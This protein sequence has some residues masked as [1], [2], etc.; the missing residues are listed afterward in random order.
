[1][2]K[3]NM[4][5][6]YARGKVGSL[7]FARRKGEQITRSRNTA[8]ANPRT[9][10]Q[11]AQRMKMYAPVKFYKQSLERFF[12]Y[13]FNVSSH[14]TVFNAFM[15]E[16]ISI[17]PWTA[18]HLVTEQA[19]VPYPARM[20]SGSI[21]ALSVVVNQNIDNS[22]A[23]GTV[24][25]SE[26][27]AGNLGASTVISVGADV[28]QTVGEVSAALISANVG[29]RLG[30]QLTFVIVGTRG[31]AIANNDVQFNSADGFDFMYKTIVLDTASDVAL[32]KL[33]L[34]ASANAIGV[35]LPYKGNNAAVGGCVII[36]RSVGG[37][38]DASNTS[39]VLNE[40]ATEIYNVMR[41][42]EYRS[43]A[44]LSYKMAD[45]AVLDPLTTAQDQ[46]TIADAPADG[47]DNPSAPIIPPTGGGEDEGGDDNTGGGGN[48]GGDEGGGDLGD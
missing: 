26:N 17:A 45:N 25:V 36:T 27:I 39:L 46:Q 35:A 2:A 37:K 32:S 18:K 5:L 30:D 21:G 13:A 41:S 3:G 19:P 43:T 22:V 1:M 10:S 48:T 44:E 14:E 23:V 16:N 28:A 9:R 20:A 8:P 24:Q 42:A 40:N 12:K 15:R 4:L 47:G 31:L 38:I 11:L 33:G 29:L 34:I 6:G 7:V